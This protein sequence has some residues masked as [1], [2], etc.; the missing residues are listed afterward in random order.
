MEEVCFEFGEIKS[1][2]FRYG[3]FDKFVRY[4]RRD[5]M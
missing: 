5:V 1:L 2:I 3:K 4:L